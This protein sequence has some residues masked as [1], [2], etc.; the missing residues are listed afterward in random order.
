MPRLSQQRKHHRRMRAGTRVSALR[1]NAISPERAKWRLGS[2]L[3]VQSASIKS[4]ER[5]A[6]SHSSKSVT[7]WACYV[8]VKRGLGQINSPS[9]ENAVRAY[10][11]CKKI[12]LHAVIYPGI[13]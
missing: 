11:W 8:A 6:E 2:I 1:T 9:A 3:A 13:G 5:A 10:L 4:P 7:G 12:R